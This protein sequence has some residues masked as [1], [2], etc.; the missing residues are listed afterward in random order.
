MITELTNQQAED[1]IY[2]I[3]RQA[4]KDLSESSWRLRLF[5]QGKFKMSE[6]Q[7]NECR[8]LKADSLQFFK[9]KWFFVM[10]DLPADKIIEICLYGNLKLRDNW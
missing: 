2:E 7:V 3:I 6:K 8:Q 1:I 5:E 10:C 9:S 4:A